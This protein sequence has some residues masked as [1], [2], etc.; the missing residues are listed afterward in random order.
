MPAKS[1]SSGGPRSYRLGLKEAKDLVD[2]APKPV[3]EN[4]SKD[5]AEAL[6]A[7]LTEAGRH[8]RNQVRSQSE[9]HQKNA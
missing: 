5:D 8:R 3:K 6:K 9:M 4:I 7:K 1:T 2:G